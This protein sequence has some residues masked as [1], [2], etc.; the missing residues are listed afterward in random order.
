MI[1][2]LIVGSIMFSYFY[3][4]VW[5]FQQSNINSGLDI[6]SIIGVVVPP[7]GVLT[8]FIHIIN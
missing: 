6:A 3:N 1:Q 2:G 4:I 7:L 8:G 5:V